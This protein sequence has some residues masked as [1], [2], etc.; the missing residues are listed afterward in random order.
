MDLSRSRS[1]SEVAPVSAWK[2][3]ESDE[4]PPPTSLLRVKALRTVAD[5]RSELT[6][7]RRTG[8]RI[9]LVPT[10]GALHAGHLSLV[11]LAKKKHKKHKKKQ[12]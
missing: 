8:L 2:W 10:M 7:A 11:K 9:G 12:A 3:T 1:T 6:S 5:L 4:P